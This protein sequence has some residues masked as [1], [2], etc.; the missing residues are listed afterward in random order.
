MSIQNLLDFYERVKPTVSEWIA[1]PVWSRY[2]AAALC[3]GFIPVTEPGSDDVSPPFKPIDPEA[4][5]PAD[6]D[7][8]RC[9]LASLRDMSPAAPL[10][11]M[12]AMKLVPPIYDP[13]T[14]NFM[15]VK[16]LLT[17]QSLITYQ[18]VCIMG[19]AVGL[20]WPAL[21]PFT[22]LDALHERI[23]EDEAHD[24][25]LPMA[26]QHPMMA[27][28]DS[29][30]S[31]AQT[32]AMV[33]SDSATEGAVPMP[34]AEPNEKQSSGRGQDRP[35]VSP[36]LRGYYTTE[37]VGGLTE[38]APGTLNKYARVGTPV[39]GF[40]PFKHEKRKAW[41]W[42]DAEQQREHDMSTKDQA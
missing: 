26:K 19:N 20:E 29:T 33:C 35:A 12:Q 37:E 30:Q 24:F 14:G 40:T 15:D 32:V 21:V 13:F 31:V 8:Y 7:L 10:K 18:W 41:H 42:R 3:S 23:R 22:L 4:V 16:V 6:A 17:R 25:D 39:N 9:Y 2:E 5:V 11:V 27:E 36:K 1:K 34:E 28:G 38:L